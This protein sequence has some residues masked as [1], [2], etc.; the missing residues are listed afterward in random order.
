MTSDLRNG[1]VVGTA[2]TAD[3][4]GAADR[5]D[6]TPVNRARR[7]DRTQHP[8]GPKRIGNCDAFLAPR[9]CARAR[10]DRQLVEDHRDIFDEH[11]VGHVRPGREALDRAACRD[12]GLFVHPMLPASRVDVDWYPRQVGQLARG[13]RRA[14]LTCQSNQHASIISLRRE[15]FDRSPAGPESPPLRSAIADRPAW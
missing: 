14:D 10:D 1:M 4:H 9:L 13:E 6:I 7:F 5:E 2:G 11:G 8:I 3:V 12:Q 15:V